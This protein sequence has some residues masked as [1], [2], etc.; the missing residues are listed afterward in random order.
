MAGTQ[1]T[2]T[3]TVGGPRGPPI[4]RVAEQTLPDAKG[5]V[6][7]WMRVPLKI[8]AGRGVAV[9]EVLGLDGRL[10]AALRDGVCCACPRL[11][12]GDLFRAHMHTVTQ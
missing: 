3:P 7:P 11:V 4:A 12:G 8:E 1:P 9:G 6:L 5:P 10:A 2:G